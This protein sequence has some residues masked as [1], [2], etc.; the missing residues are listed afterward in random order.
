MLR[1]LSLLPRRRRRF[2]TRSVERRVIYTVSLSLL[3]QQY[4]RGCLTL[5]EIW[6]CLFFFIALD[7]RAAISVRISTDETC[8]KKSAGGIEIF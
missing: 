3:I 6:P 8:W 2:S 7:D 1:I 5:S 4:T